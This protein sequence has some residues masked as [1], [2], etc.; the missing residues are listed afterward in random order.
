MCPRTL[1]SALTT[2]QAAVG[3]MPQSGLRTALRSRRTYIFF[4]TDRVRRVLLFSPATLQEALTSSTSRIYFR[5]TLQELCSL[6][7]CTLSSAQ[8]LEGG[9]PFIKVFDAFLLCRR[10]FLVSA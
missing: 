6:I 7:Q 4:W 5:M 9:K 2:A 10:L 3:A 8:E 1:E